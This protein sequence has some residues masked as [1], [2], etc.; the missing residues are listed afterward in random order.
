MNVTLNTGSHAIV[1]RATASGGTYFKVS[2]DGFTAP[3]A[4]WFPLAAL[5]AAGND[6]VALLAW[7]PAITVVP[8]IP[9]SMAPASV[10]VAA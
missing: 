7:S 10:K 2:Y 1:N 4:R 5:V 3:L 6:E 9:V 8:R